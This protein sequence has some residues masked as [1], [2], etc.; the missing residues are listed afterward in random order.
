[1]EKNDKNIYLSVGE[2]SKTLGI[3]TEYIRHYVQEGIISPHKN[4]ENNYWEYSS[5]DF[6]RL[7]D[8]LFYRSMGLSIKEIKMIMDGVPVENIGDIIKRRRDELIGDIKKV[9][10]MLQHL[11]LWEECYQNELASLGVFR[12]GPMPTEYRREQYIT[13]TQHMA[14]CLRQCFDLDKE[15]WE[16]LSISFY[17][18][19]GQPEKGLQ[20][21]FSFNENTRL[22]LCNAKI[23]SVEERADKCLITEVRFSEDVD[24]MINP[25][26]DYAKEHDIAL[27]GEFY[28]REET[29]Y[30]CEG[31]RM[32]LYKIYAP[33]LK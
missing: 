17:Y 30:Y 21:Y 9:V 25:M 18:N 3:S 27:T 33:I 26:L 13:E 16:S 32:G 24:S 14:Y 28:G 29:N 12:I 20:K 22:K 4:R 2:V 5:E 10:E 6:V 8:V 1:M 7:S 31:K 15:D 19:I 23:G 11:D